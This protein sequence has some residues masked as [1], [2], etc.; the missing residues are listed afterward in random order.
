[1][2]FSPPAL[3][4]RGLTAA[5]L[6]GGLGLWFR[7]TF[8]GKV[9]TGGGECLVRVSRATPDPELLAEFHL[10]PPGAAGARVPLDAVAKVRRGCDDP[11]QLASL[12]GQPGVMFSVN[13]IG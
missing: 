5:D 13:K 1:M 10:Q 8:A 7:D 9:E 4:A 6:A 12:G 2:E 3:A 11:R